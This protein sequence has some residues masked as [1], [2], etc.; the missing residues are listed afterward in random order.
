MSFALEW[1]RKLEF[2]VQRCLKSNENNLIGGKCGSTYID[3]N[4]HALLSKRFGSAF[5]DLSFGQKG[6]GGKLMNAFQ[7]FKRDFGRTD[8]ADEREIGPINLDVPES[9]YYDPDDRMVLLS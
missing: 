4:F 9:E 6:P 1:V 5:D 7:V 8:N 2:A 3:R